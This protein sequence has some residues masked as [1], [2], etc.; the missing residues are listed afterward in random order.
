MA[1]RSEGSG[2]SITISAWWDDEKQATLAIFC[3]G[4]IFQRRASCKI[5]HYVGC[6]AQK[7][8]YV[9]AKVRL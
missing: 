8:Q 4:R 3:G 5:A 9:V 7:T 1:E 6:F 2:C